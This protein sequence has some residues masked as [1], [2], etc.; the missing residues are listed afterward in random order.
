MLQEEE[1]IQAF[2]NLGLTY[3]QAKV[4]VT[5]LKLGSSSANVKKIALNAAIARQDIY[6]ILPVLENYGLVEKIIAIPTRYRPVALEDGLSL[7]MEQRTKEYQELQKKAKM[8]L[9]NFVPQEPQ[10]FESA[11]QFRITSA[12]PLFLKRIKDGI[13]QVENSIDLIYDDSLLRAIVFDTVD[14][15]KRAIARGVKIRVVMTEGEQALDKNLESLAKSPSFE[16]HLAKEDV[17]VGLVIFDD[18]EVEFQATQSIVPTLWSN[19]RN[20]VKL[21][22]VYFY[23]M[24]Q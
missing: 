24:W 4:Y 20:I 14:D 17:P 2:T 19:N 7:L 12:R 23:S 21:A 6:R 9:K 8:V 11:S 22:Q 10:Y 3:L 18:K 15:F 5:L 13:T 1:P 16:L